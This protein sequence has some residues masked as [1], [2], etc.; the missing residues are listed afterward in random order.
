VQRSSAQLRHVLAAIVKLPNVESFPSDK[1]TKQQ[2]GF[3]QLLL[4]LP[5]V[6]AKLLEPQAFPTAWQDN[7]VVSTLGSALQALL[8]TSSLAGLNHEVDSHSM[9]HLPALARHWQQT[10]LLSRLALAMQG[11]AQVLPQQQQQQQQQA[12]TEDASPQQ[13]QQQPDMQLVLLPYRL[14]YVW[15]TVDTVLDR[16]LSYPHKDASCAAKAA[17]ALV[18][19]TAQGMTADTPAVCFD[20]LLDVALRLLFTPVFGRCLLMGTSVPTV[21]GQNLKDMQRLCSSPQLLQVLLMLL[22]LQCRHA[23]TEQHM[24]PNTAAPSSSSSSSSSGDDLSGPRPWQCVCGC[25]ITASSSSSRSDA[26]AANA[27][28]P[29]VPQPQLQSLQARIDTLWQ[30]AGFKPELLPAFEAGMLNT[31]IWQQR[32]VLST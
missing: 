25:G 23:I 15:L 1:Q 2:K 17:A 18:V 26:A 3:D 20:R 22:A 31:L 9:P 24:K 7:A 5:E 19:A 6:L 29:S 10:G 11:L 21:N 14:S 16:G 27:V 13:Q 8:H 32:T 28:I 12:A 30:Q 4:L